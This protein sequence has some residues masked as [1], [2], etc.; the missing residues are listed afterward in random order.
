MGSRTVASL[1][2]DVRYRADIRGMT[3]RH[4]DS[5]IRRLLSQSFR[6]C[7]AKLTENGFT[8]FLASTTP[9]ALSTSTPSDGDYTSIPVPDDSSSIL[10][11]D[12]DL[13][14]GR[15]V[16]MEPMS[17]SARHDY[18]DRGGPPRSWCIFSL[19]TTTPDT[20][21]TAG[22]IRLY[23][24]TDSAYNYV[25]TYLTQFPELSNDNHVVHGFDGDWFE[26]VVWDVV[27][28]LS[29]SDNDSQG[30]YQIAMQERM[31][32]EQRVMTNISRYN[33]TGPISPRRG[34]GNYRYNWRY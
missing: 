20:T 11:V 21:L 30:T 27:I 17:F 3:D 26:W 1:I 33:R 4:P 10:G 8:G 5:D 28:K 22:S 6:G 29:A 15:W 25:I 23:P 24:K 12:I 2:D 13:G 16:S 7:R 19:P 14:S 34:R 18:I 9:A 32:V 31:L